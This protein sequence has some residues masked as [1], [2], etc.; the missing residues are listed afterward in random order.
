MIAPR[1]I[2]PASITITANIAAYIGCW[3]VAT[4]PAERRATFTEE[5]TELAGMHV[6]YCRLLPISRLTPHPTRQDFIGDPKG[7]SGATSAN[8][9]AG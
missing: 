3:C 1:C 6:H 4:V 2:K 8:P 5:A 7:G 9:V